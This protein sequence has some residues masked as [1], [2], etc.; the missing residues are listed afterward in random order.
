MCQPWLPLPSPQ[1]SFRQCA[2]QPQE[3]SWQNRIWRVFV[4][5]SN[6]NTMQSFSPTLALVSVAH[7][8][9]HRNPLPAPRESTLHSPMGVLC[10]GPFLCWPTRGGVRASLS[11]ANKIQ[12]GGSEMTG[13]TVPPPCFSCLHTKQSIKATLIKM[14]SPGC[15]HPGS[16]PS[17]CVPEGYEGQTM[18]RWSTCCLVD[19][20]FSTPHFRT[21]H[22]G[23]RGS[24]HSWS[25]PFPSPPHWKQHIPTMGEW[26]VKMTEVSERAKLTCLI[27]DKISTFIK[28]W[29]P[30][31]NFLLK[32]AKY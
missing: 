5:R 6:K 24:P 17:G 31:M 18:L 19:R 9:S 25:S 23:K 20:C 30:F 15:Y 10:L 2:N 3:S 32:M 8:G 16:V 7:R 4:H 28:D 26:V 11:F 13:K 1:L 29:K 22:E 14:G 27:R 12:K 21:E